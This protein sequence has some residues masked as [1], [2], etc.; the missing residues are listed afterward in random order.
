[1]IL[2]VDTDILSAL[3]KVT[4]LPLL[5]SLLQTT[6]LQIAPGVFRELAHSLNLRRR[7]AEEVLSLVSA[8]QIQVIPLTEE[9]ATFRDTLPGTLG[10]GERENITIAK[11]RGGMVL[12]NESRVAHCCQQ[13]KVPCLRLPD[14][15]R[16]LWVEG[17]VSK[18]E[19]QDIIT[20]LQVKDRM[21]F[22]QSTLDV[23]FADERNLVG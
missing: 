11:E 14:I 12:S 3:A 13:H 5:F 21:Q 22:K 1:M 18:Q 9:E 2:L 7:Y 23:I 16:A 20:D 19:V 17:I 15:L 10:A 6:S 4:R 8:G